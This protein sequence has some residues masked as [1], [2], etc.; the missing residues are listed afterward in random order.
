MPSWLAEC[1]KDLLMAQIWEGVDA[2]QVYGTAMPIIV[3]TGDSGGGAW[4]NPKNGKLDA[5]NIKSASFYMNGSC[6]AEHNEDA[7]FI[8]HMAHLASEMPMG[9][10]TM[11]FAFDW[12]YND[13]GQPVKE[14]SIF[15][16]SDAYA[17]KLH[18]QYHNILSGSPRIHPFRADF[19]KI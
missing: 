19:L 2:N 10:K 17:A 11:L 16:I 8:S 12:V 14:N 9:Y 7:S 6:I 4:F 13:I 5:P 3:V 18:K 1:T 15:N